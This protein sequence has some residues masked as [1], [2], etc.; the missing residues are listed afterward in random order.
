M[1]FIARQLNFES[2]LWVVEDTYFH[3]HD[4]ILKSDQD[5]LVYS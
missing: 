3:R 2:F 5:K 1:N 4:R